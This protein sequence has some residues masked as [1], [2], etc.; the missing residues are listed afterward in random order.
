MFVGVIFLDISKAF[1]TVNHAVLLGKLGNLGVNSI[2]Y[3]WFHSYLMERQQST[4]VDNFK[5]NNLIIPSGVPQGSVLGPLLFSVYLN[6]LP[7]CTQGPTS[8]LL[9]ADDTCPSFASKSIHEINSILNTTISNVSSWLNQNGL[10][11]NIS[12]TKCMLIHPVRKPPKECLNIQISGTQ[13]E[14]V[15]SYK[16]L[17]LILNSTLTLDAHIKFITT[18]V[19][20]NLALL[21]RL[22]WF[23]PQ[24]ALITF[25]KTYIIP[26]FDYCDAVWYSIPARLSHQLEVLQ[27]CAARIIL[28]EKRIFS[29]TILKQRLGWTTLELRRKHHLYLNI[30]KTIH[31]IHPPYLCNL[32][33][34]QS[35]IYQYN[36]REA[37]LNLHPPLPSTVN[38]KRAYS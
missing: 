2:A 15:T 31:Q 23:L 22:S 6:D 10:K 37:S 38:G 9:F 28:K 7:S 34:R 8:T 27:N 26:S 35:S 33:I 5:S 13:I 18:K 1:D 14:Q 12:K 11:L 36:T 20:R 21:R 3:K 17:R 25:Y 4:I 32:A 19:K 30:F 29:A 24:S 16:Y